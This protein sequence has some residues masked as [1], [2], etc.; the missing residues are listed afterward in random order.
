MPVLLGLAVVAGLVLRFVAGQALWLDEAQSVEIARLPLSGGNSLWQALREDGSPPLYY[1]LLHG[2]IELFGTGSRT[3]RGLSAV[4]NLACAVPLWYL[5]RR[6]IGPRAARVAMLI[7]IT[8]PFAMYFATETRMY[9]LLLLLALLGGLALEKTLRAPSIGSVVGLGFAAVAVALTHYWSLYLLFTLGLLLLVGAVRGSFPSAKRNRR[10]ALLGLVLGG[11]LFLPWLPNF[12]YQGKHT[13]TPWGEPASFAAVVHA[14]G[15]WSGGPTTVGRALLLVSIALLTAAVFGSPAGRHQIL[16]DLRGHEPGRLLLVLSLGTLFVAVSV[17]LLVGNAWADR[18]T[19][20][21]FAPYL[22]AVALGTERIADPKLLRVTLVLLAVL[23]VIAGG[24][25]IRLQRTQANEVASFLR[26]EAHSGDVLL[27][28]PDQLGPGLARQKLPPGMVTHVIPTYAPVGRV[29]WRDYQQRNSAADGGAL[30]NRALAEAG[31][32]ATVWLAFNGEYR[33]YENLCPNV[34]EQ[35]NSARKV[36][37]VIQA[38]KPS[39][40]YERLELYQY[41]PKR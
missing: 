9:S 36:K 22:L 37:Q 39:Q 30:A 3:V 19:V 16:I 11:M 24:Q 10:L 13:G 7:L 17:G 15:Q 1:L 4:L 40:S 31:P 41:A 12:L 35:L 33:T 8:S 32:N 6:V 18:Y 25:Q 23:G 28:C 14:F 38:R 20:T 5:A 2:W 29:D 34:R 21:A 27:V 26:A